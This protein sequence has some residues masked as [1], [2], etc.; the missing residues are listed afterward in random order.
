[1][2]S[3]MASPFSAPFRYGTASRIVVCVTNPPRVSSSNCIVG[4]G[5]TNSLTLGGRF[6]G[7]SLSLNPSEKR[8]W[9]SS[10]HGRNLRSRGTAQWSAQKKKSGF[11]GTEHVVASFVKPVL[12]RERGRVEH[13]HPR[14][15][16]LGNFNRM[17]RRHQQHDVEE[18]FYV[19]S[20][21]VDGT[22][23][24][25]QLMCHVWRSPG[26]LLRGLGVVGI[27]GARPQ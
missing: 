17:T 15:P 9:R 8:D 27:R 13:A 19:M 25:E 1:M 26:P 6:L 24:H 11:E 16:T 10:S 7:L 4:V 21:Q 20:V 3:R 14:L 5:L 23:S 2:G 12:I 18:R 22:F